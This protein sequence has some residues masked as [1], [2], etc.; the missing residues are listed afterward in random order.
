[1]KMFYLDIILSVCFCASIVNTGYSQ[2]GWVQQ[3]LPAQV[4]G[5]FGIHSLDSQN[6]W[7]VG[8]NGTIL[9]SSDGGA[10]WSEIN[11]PVTYPLYNVH[12]INADTGWFGGNHASITEVMRTTDRGLSWESQI[13]Y[14]PSDLGTN[15]IE[16]IQGGP[17]EAP[18]GFVT[19]GLSNVWRTDDYGV[20]WVT[21]PIGGCGAGDLESICF[22]DRNEGWFVGTPSAASE[23]SIVH[24]TDGGQTFTIQT[25]PT[26]PDIKLNG[27]CF[28]DNQ[29]GIAVGLSGTMLYTADGGQN[30]EIRPS[31]A[32]GNRWQSVYMTETGKAWAVGQN[33][34]I[35]Y[36]TDWGYNWTLQSSGVSTELWEVHF[37]N[38]NEG[39][40]VGGL[41]QGFILHTMN[42]GITDISEPVNNAIENYKLAQNYPNPFNPET[43]IGWQLAVSSHIKL[44]IYNVN[45]Q[46]VESL[47]NER[48]PVGLYSVRFDGSDL[49]SGVYYY[50]LE[51]DDYK[52]VKKMIL[53]K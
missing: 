48:F 16:F 53:L 49:P 52:E 45:G 1:M 5:L 43:V 41:G 42:G 36:S 9:N 11:S 25:N 21:S 51:A 47:I 4:P 6:I 3:N 10:S 7:A 28:A 32:P 23:V 40:I 37:I 17:G 19:A 8:D 20:N 34:N 46:M 13:L 2:T 15:D 44:N 18:R 12:F 39:W 24:T 50:Q 38:D 33:G 35:A 31:P 14:T 30:W 22:I 26:D 29:H 27:V